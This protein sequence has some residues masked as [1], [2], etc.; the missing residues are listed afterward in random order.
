MNTVKLNAYAKINLS[1]NIT[2]KLE[3]G[4]HSLEM[5]MQSISLHD[6]VTVKKTDGGIRILCGDPS[7]PTDR[8]NIAY[9]CAESFF[10]HYGISGG[11]DIEIQKH[12]PSQ[13]GM[14]GGSA[15]GA[16]VLHALNTLYD[17]GCSEND[18]CKLGVDIGADIPFCIKGGTLLAKG[19][20]EQLTDLPAMPDCFIA[21]AKPDCGVNTANAFA[22]YDSCGVQQNADTSGIISALDAQSLPKIGALLC[23]ALECV[24]I[25]D[26]SKSI[27]GIMLEND[28]LGALMTGSGSAV[29][30][31]FGTQKAAENCLYKIDAP[32]KAVCRPVT[33]G[34]KIIFQD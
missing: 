28:A 23:N 16:A 21:L 33:H 18:L 19:I 17:S 12:I 5:V 34:V 10:A 20:G 3:N 2:G 30:G 22:E 14:A 27:K 26:K 32:F 13:A 31:L 25:P 6:V 1:L 8:R 9:K 4:Y 11:A 7:V 29:Y 15:D 24:C